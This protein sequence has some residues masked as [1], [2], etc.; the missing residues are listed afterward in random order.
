M[1]YLNIQHAVHNTMNDTFPPQT[2]NNIFCF[3]RNG[4][5]GKF[6]FHYKNKIKNLLS[7][8]YQIL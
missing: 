7:Y 2:Q 5:F 1:N 8:K 6:T 4:S 3:F